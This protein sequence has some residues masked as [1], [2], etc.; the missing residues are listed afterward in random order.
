MLHDH[1]RVI[2]IDEPW[3]CGYWAGR[4]GVTLPELT[5]AVRQVGGLVADVQRFLGPVRNP[6]D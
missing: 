4:L 1:L 3:E 5:N 2:D 6:L